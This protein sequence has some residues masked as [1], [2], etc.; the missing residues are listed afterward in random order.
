MGFAAG[1]FAAG[2]AK[3]GVGGGVTSCLFELAGVGDDDDLALI[4]NMA[5]LAEVSGFWE[6]MTILAGTLVEG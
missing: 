3:G 6:V 1:F 2:S 5:D 4:D